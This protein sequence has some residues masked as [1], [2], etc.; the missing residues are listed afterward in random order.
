MYPNSTMNTTLDVAYLMILVDSSRLQNN[1]QLLAFLY[2]ESYLGASTFYSFKKLSEEKA[3]KLTFSWITHSI[4]QYPKH[5]AEAFHGNLTKIC[6]VQGNTCSQSIIWPFS[7]EKKKSKIM[8]VA[9]KREMHIMINA[10]WDLGDISSGRTIYLPPIIMISIFY[11]TLHGNSEALSLN[12][13]L[14]L[15]F[16]SLFVFWFHE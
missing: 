2:I 1:P 12:S 6:N 15:S 3:Y 7:R 4:Q 8:P 13:A 14:W 11:G 9:L 16:D 10:L 5:F